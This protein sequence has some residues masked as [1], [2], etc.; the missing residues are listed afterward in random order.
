MNIEVRKTEGTDEKPLKWGVFLGE[1]LL[2][3]SKAR[4]DADLHKSVLDKAF[5][6]EYNRGFKN[7]QADERLMRDA[8]YC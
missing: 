8:I 4:S 7:G 5:K 2:G 3:E 1:Y 6:N